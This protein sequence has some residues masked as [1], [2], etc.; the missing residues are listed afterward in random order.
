MLV[1]RKSN[2]NT[3]YSASLF[4]F[5]L[6]P[7]KFQLFVGSVVVYLF[8]L[9][10]SLQAGTKEEAE[11]IDPTILVGR[12]HTERTVA[13]FDFYNKFIRENDSTRVF[14]FIKQV[15][16]L[17]I[18]HD[19]EEL[20]LESDLMVL[21]YYAWKRIGLEPEFAPR[22]KE[23]M[24]KAKKANALWLESRLENLWGAEQF[25]YGNY[26]LSHI[27][28]NRSAKLL[29]NETAAEYPIKRINYYLLAILH[30]TFREYDK[31][32]DEL[33]QYMATGT[34][35]DLYYYR[36]GALNYM[37]V[38]FSERG[39]LDSSD[40]YHNQYLHW[41][42][43]NKDT[44]RMVVAWGNL[45]ENLYKRG[46]Y[47]EAWPLIIKDYEWMRT[48]RSGNAANAA[49]LLADIA[50]IEGDLDKA[51]HYASDAYTLANAASNRFARLSKFFPVLIK[52]Y[53]AEGKVDLVDVYLDSMAIV[54]DSL[55]Y[56]FD[57]TMLTRADQRLQL[58]ELEKDAQRIK[59]ETL[60][61]VMTRNIII[62]SLVFLFIVVLLLFNRHKLKVEKER[63]HVESELR[64]AEL[65][66]QEFL[67]TL[68]TKQS[69]MEMLQEE[70][71]V[72]KYQ[73]N[74][75]PTEEE[76]PSLEEISIL[77]DED[78]LRFRQLFNRVHNGYL[79]RV[80]SAYP[81]L[82]ETDL[83]F[84]ALTKLRMPPKQMMVTLGVG[85]SAVR[86][87]RLRLR[88]KLGITAETD[89]HTFLEA[90]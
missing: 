17:A 56:I 41:A 85:D 68:Q 28:L 29:E 87:Y 66:L 31:V 34:T 7:V 46:S 11:P 18:V 9:T 43:E 40:Y 14:S 75:K 84:V 59:T 32:I 58:E 49:T 65:H 69:E 52:L 12:T 61:T 60:R 45:G 81:K 90:I 82:S 36:M 50:L 38:A 47:T 1:S 72:L 79:N 24:Q 55:E 53:A 73:D 57:R 27:H 13:L 8:A 26:E 88:T 2:D 23:L 15:E 5:F 33:H 19:D 74:G 62:L 80:A 39:M 4:S 64:L 10:A 51:R 25:T 16:Q 6:A 89:L 76:V 37:A 35:N 21:H 77:T 70:L 63:E 78:W 20:M 22:Y 30:N 67:N 44:T 86:Q 42:I 3:T 71:S 54:K 83:C 48:H